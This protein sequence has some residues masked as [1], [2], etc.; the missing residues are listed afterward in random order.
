MSGQE[1]RPRAAA[2]YTRISDDRTGEA[3]GVKRQEQDCREI[4]ARRG[5]PVA[6]VYSDNDT[7]AYSGKARPG[8]ER[9]LEDLRAGVVDAVIAWH[10]DR[11][12]R[13]PRELEDFIDVVEDAKAAVLTVK[14]GDY[15]LTTAAGRQNARIVGAVARGESERMG[16]RI[17]RK[18]EE[19]AAAGKINGGGSRPF[20]YEVDR[21][22][23]RTSEAR[24]IR[25][26]AQ[27]V[28]AGESLSGIVREWNATGLKTTGGMVWDVSGLR[29]VLVSAR[30]SGRREHHGAIVGQAVWKGIISAEDGDRLRAMLG[31]ARG[32]RP[33]PP[34]RFLLTGFLRCG[35]CGVALAA[36][37][38]ATRVAERASGEKY[39]TLAYAC[40]RHP[41]SRPTACG[42]LRVRAAALEELLTEMTF[43]AVDSAKLAARIADRRRGEERVTALDDVTA[44]EADLQRLAA[45][46]GEGRVPYSEWTAAR[47]PLE[48]RLSDARRRLDVENGTL[49]LNGYTGKTG[50]LRKAWP[51]LSIDRRRA[52]LGVVLDSVTVKPANPATPRNRFDPERI[53]VAWRV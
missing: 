53:E 22:T 37:R 19:L 5:W 14:A 40:S 29:T 2:I 28:L 45:D 32:R 35:R 48:R 47:G 46:F 41:R 34:T 51:S 16:E 10:P 12:Q 52:I 38:A 33:G 27:R 24:L 17:R 18:H 44:I 9:L 13:S 20:G 8:Y 15:D 3:A 6:A 36:S 30:I 26:A 23:V 1:R 25:D 50:A 31:R 42:R 49:P 4:A 39:A 7:S 11:L 43:A 21:V